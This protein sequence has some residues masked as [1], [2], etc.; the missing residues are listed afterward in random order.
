MKQRKATGVTC[1]RCCYTLKA[2]RFDLFAIARGWRRRAFLAFR[3][4]ALLGLG[5]LALFTLAHASTIEGM[6]PLKVV[7]V[8]DVEATNQ[9][10]FLGWSLTP[11]LSRRFLLCSCLCSLISEWISLSVNFA[12]TAFLPCLRFAISHSLC[13][14]RVQSGVFHFLEQLTG[15]VAVGVI[16]CTSGAD[17]LACLVC[18]PP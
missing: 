10:R 2:L 1:D 9:C 17:V 18:C 4:F 12:T 3:F 13:V 7:L 16:G 8:G 11:I 6:M 15:R 14:G 5:S